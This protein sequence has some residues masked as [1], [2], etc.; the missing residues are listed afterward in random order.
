MKLAAVF[1]ERKD[2]SC[3]L[4]ETPGKTEK[5]DWLH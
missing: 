1:R 3:C 4:Q 2:V 5:D